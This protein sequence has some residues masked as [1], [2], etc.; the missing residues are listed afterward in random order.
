MS[1][2]ACVFFNSFVHFLPMESHT[3]FSIFKKW[4]PL[5]GYPY[6][7]VKLFKRFQRFLLPFFYCLACLLLLPSFFF[8]FFLTTASCPLFF[9]FFFC[10]L[11]CKP[12]IQKCFLFQWE[13][14]NATWRNIDWLLVCVG[15]KS[16][17]IWDCYFFFLFKNLVVFFFFLKDSFGRGDIRT[18]LLHVFW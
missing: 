4:D 6:L 8:F 2:I 17:S 1:I 10:P 18:I 3:Q 14:N 9:F 15:G 11:S 16:R 7:S 13:C 12:Q 5:T